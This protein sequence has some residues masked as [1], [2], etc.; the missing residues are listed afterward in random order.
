[1]SFRLLPGMSLTLKE[2]LQKN[3]YKCTQIINGQLHRAILA[4]VAT[5][6]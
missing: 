6:N 4:G 5:V 1:M 3:K 2:K